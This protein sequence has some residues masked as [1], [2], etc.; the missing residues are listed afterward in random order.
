MPQV[1]SKA[2]SRAPQAVLSGFG[3]RIS[4]TGA[5]LVDVEATEYI[6]H[7]A[8]VQGI[9]LFGGHLAT[10]ALMVWK[11]VISNVPVPYMGS[12]I[13]RFKTALGRTSR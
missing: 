7:K 10:R 3:I 2:S 9:A 8:L 1:W 5:V 13:R 6:F 4:R 12:M 11:A